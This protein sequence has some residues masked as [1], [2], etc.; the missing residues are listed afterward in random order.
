V[1]AEP[2][3]AGNGFGAFRIRVLLAMML[4]VSAVAGGGLWFA[5]RNAADEARGEFQREFSAALAST[6]SVREVRHA[7]LAERARALARRPRIHAALED[8]APE[9]LYPSAHDELADVLGGAD[10]GMAGLPYALHARFYRF[11]DA[12]GAVIP[13]PVPLHAGSAEAGT[14]D[15]GML[16]AEEESRLALPGLPE[17]PQIGYLPRGGAADGGLDEVIAMPIVSSEN[18]DRIAAIV[19]GFRPA[20]F[21]GAED[22]HSGI[23]AAGRLHLTSLSSRGQELLSAEMDRETARPGH[24]EGSFTTQA[25]GA[26]EL[27]FFTRLNPGSRFPPA[28]Q[29]SLFPLANLRAHQQRLLWQFGGAAAVLLVAAFGASHLLAGRLSRPVERLAADSEEHRSGRVRAEAALETTS[30]ELA[31]SARFSAD[32]SHQLKTPVTVLRAGL[33]EMLAVRDLQPEQREEI[34]SLIHQTFRLASIIDDLL[35]LSRMDAGRLRLNLV[36]VNLSDLIAGWL[37][38]LGALPD[39]H[40]LDIKTDYPAALPVL[41]EA[42]YTTLILQNLLENA[43]KYNRV[44]GNIRVTARHEGDWITVAI[45][46][47]GRPIPPSSREHIF[48]R[49]HRGN[50]GE[51]VPGHGLGLNLARELARLHGGDLRLVRSEGDWTEFELSLRSAEAQSAVL[52]VQ[53]A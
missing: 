6:R 12:H 13:P 31:R 53:E 51:D 47:T 2:K 22:I 48:E 39:G 3:A 41:G 20:E 25:D 23:W 26:P 42:R 27:L 5:Q 43:R 9:L 4:L 14:P 36:G 50:A 1:S 46:N 21:A 52:K 40:A 24:P 17:E 30:R 49:F 33:E 44:G 18:G 34:A 45:G 15:T 7:L 28:Y 10:A 19:L 37:D 38:D 29:V 11:L 16:G 8:G 32:A 35:L